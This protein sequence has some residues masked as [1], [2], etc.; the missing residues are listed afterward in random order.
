MVLLDPLRT[1]KVGVSRLPLTV[2]FYVYV[3]WKL[4]DSKLTT[5]SRS[6]KVCCFILRARIGRIPTQTLH[7]MYLNSFL[8]RSYVWCGSLSLWT[9][10]RWIVRLLKKWWIGFLSGAWSISPTPFLNVG[11]VLDFAAAWGNCLKEK[12]ILLV[13][14]YDSFWCIRKARNDKVFNKRSVF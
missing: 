5:S 7:Q 11:D 8:Y 12:N 6:V 9:A 1:L 13:F 3:L 4:I 10:Y 2:D 14:P